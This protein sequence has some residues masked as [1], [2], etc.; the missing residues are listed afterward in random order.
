MR[1]KSAPVRLFLTYRDALIV[2]A[3]LVLDA[4]PLYLAT[5]HIHGIT[6]VI[7]PT[8]DA[9][10]RD[11]YHHRHGREQVRRAQQK[12]PAHRPNSLHCH[13]C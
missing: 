9:A 2:H 8:Y 11:T 5:S 1:S 3:R 12:E 10:I 6:P 13:D 7:N 4:K